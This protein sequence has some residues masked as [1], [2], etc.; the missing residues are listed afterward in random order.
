MVQLQWLAMTL[1]MFVPGLMALD[2]DGH[3]HVNFDEFNKVII[4]GMPRRGVRDFT[5][6]DCGRD[7]Q[8]GGYKCHYT[9]EGAIPVGQIEYFESIVTCFGMRPQIGYST[10][11]ATSCRLVEF[12]NYVCLCKVA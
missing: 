8:I 1:A 5:A 2:P 11:T 9:G 4:R 7:S 6:V 12:S 10:I 3:H